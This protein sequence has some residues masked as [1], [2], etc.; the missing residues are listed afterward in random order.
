[1]Y[2]L[3]SERKSTLCHDIPYLQSEFQVMVDDEINWHNQQLLLRV[4]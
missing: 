4:L 1:M 2:A 3:L